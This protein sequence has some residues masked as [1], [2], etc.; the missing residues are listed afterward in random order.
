MI[1]AGW[2]LSIIFMSIG[3]WAQTGLDAYLKDNNS[4]LSSELQSGKLTEGDFS[5]SQYILLGEVHGFADVQDVDMALLK[6]LNSKY[7]LKHYIAE[8]DDA[9]AWLLN[10]YLA[11]GDESL[12]HSVFR[13]WERDTAQW[14]N[15]PYFSKYQKLYEYQKQLLPNQKVTVV[16]IDQPQDYNIVKQYLA[17]LNQAFKGQAFQPEIDQLNKAINEEKKA[18]I[19]QAAVALLA[20]I[21]KEKSKGARA[22]GSNYRPLLLLLNNLSSTNKTRDSVMFDNLQRYINT[23]QLQHAKMYG[24]LGFFHCLQA[25]YN[26]SSPFAYLLKKTMKAK[27]TSIVSYYK[28]GLIMMPY[29][30]QM[31]QMIPAAVATQ[32]WSQYPA[33]SKSQKYLPLPYSNDQSNPMM[34]K[35]DQME[36]LAR[37]SL[38][39][40]VYLFKLNR[41]NSPF[42]TQKTFAEVKGIMGLRLSDAASNTTDAFQ[43]ILLFRN[44]QAASPK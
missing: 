31:K 30:A 24:F 40:S 7:Q 35:M 18:A 4:E 14:A 16:G 13:S 20:Q 1:K 3:V 2:L 25:S 38:P 29:N 44:P 11:T 43:Y 26:Q 37:L 39:S 21:D 27:V 32:F 41:D 12:L 9:K 5:E 34:E 19:A 15:L 8:V 23:Y 33:F 28:D 10:K 17:F 42:Q 36:S 6:L 22:W